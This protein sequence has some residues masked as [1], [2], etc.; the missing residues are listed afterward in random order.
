L[1]HPGGQ[2][3]ELSIEFRE[4]VPPVPRTVLS[5]DTGRPEDVPVSI[6]YT[7]ILGPP[8][9]T[10]RNGRALEIKSPSNGES[11]KADAHSLDHPENRT[12]I[13][14]DVS[15]KIVTLLLDLDGQRK[16]LGD[17]RFIPKFVLFDVVRQGF[18]NKM[19]SM[20]FYYGQQCFWDTPVTPDSG[21]NSGGRSDSPLP[22]QIP[23]PL[24][25]PTAQPSPARP[26][27]P[28]A[29]PSLPDADAQG[30]L[31]YPGAR[32]NYTNP[33]VA[34]GR[35]ADSVVVICQTGVARYYY[36]GFGLQNGLSVEIDNPLRTGAGFV[37]TNNG[38]QYSVS[39]NGLVI[40]QR[41]TVISNEPMLEYWSGSLVPPNPATAGI[42]FQPPS[43]NI[44]CSLGEFNGKGTVVCEIGEHDYPPPPNSP[45]GCTAADRYRFI[46]NQG[47]APHAECTPY[48]IIT[49]P[50]P[51]LDYGQR[52]SVD[53]NHL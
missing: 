31:N 46:L 39:P 48:P 9:G 37:A 32:C 42:L 30:F 51:T 17:G 24:P 22:A 2:E 27:P 14:A 18:R 34:I 44:G 21:Q 7:V 41:S 3:V 5:P 53:G 26:A 38:V 13:S 10:G 1:T 43:G 4:A 25:A 23:P 36:K 28:S 19:P 45:P 49:G 52:Q 6:E 47:Y 15:G 33:A 12:L 16:L 29:Q 11:W 20:V 50:I 8:A 40:S 35:T